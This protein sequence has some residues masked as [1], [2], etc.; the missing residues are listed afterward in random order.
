[1][2]FVNETLRKGMRHFPAFHWLWN[3][4]EILFENGLFS[5]IFSMG[6]IFIAIFFR[7]MPLSQKLSIWLSFLV[8]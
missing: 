6:E 3:H 5:G 2:A 8:I 1:M 7:E 4:V